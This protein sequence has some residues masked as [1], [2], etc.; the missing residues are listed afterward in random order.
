MVKSN[1]AYWREREWQLKQFKNDDKFNQKL[2]HYYDQLIASI[3]K[4][5]DREIVS[6][7][8]RNNT[9]TY[10]ARASVTSADIAAYELEAQE[11]VR[12]A[13]LMRAAGHHV[14]YADFSDEVNE[15]M[16]IYNATMRINRLEL[17]KSQIGLQMIDCGI[18]VNQAIVDKVSKDYTDELKRQAG[19]LKVTTK[20]DQLW[21][22]S[23]VAKQIMVQFNGATFSQRIWANQD[24]L[25]ATLDAVISVGVIQGKNP[26]QMARLLKNQVRSTINNHRYVTERIARTES[27][28]VQHAAQVKSL[29][30]NGYHWCK[31]FTEPGACRVCREI[32]GNDRY[33]EGLGVY[34]VKEAPEVPVHPNCRCSISAFYKGEDW[35]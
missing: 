17:L 3:N 6:L 25:K 11:L 9:S 7:A 13:E 35:L 28:R 22:S 26:R 1:N 33:G 5:I 16:R 4:E 30:D 27:A 23:D 18:Q 20:S 10:N 15:R 34:P 31:W 24:A 8:S 19:I 21:A 14:T 29:T 2:K 12:Q 32:A